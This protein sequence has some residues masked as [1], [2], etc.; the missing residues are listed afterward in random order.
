MRVNEIEEIDRARSQLTEAV[1]ISVSINA[2]LR[3]I[4]LNNLSYQIDKLK[5]S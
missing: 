3:N 1:G 2:F 4:I 5:K